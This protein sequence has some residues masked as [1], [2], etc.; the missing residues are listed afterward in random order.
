MEQIKIAVQIAKEKWVNTVGDDYR[1]ARID[2]PTEYNS[3][4]AHHATGY[5]YDQES[6]SDWETIGVINGYVV[7]KDKYGYEIYEVQ[8]PDGDTEI[9][10]RHDPCGKM[11][12]AKI[13]RHITARDDD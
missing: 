7:G 11:R 3:N 5:E 13:A 6:R 8:M 10:E 12:A 4:P 2:E 9:I 1:L